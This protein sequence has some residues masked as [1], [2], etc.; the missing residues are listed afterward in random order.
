[1]P[2]W[3]RHGAR[4]LD[5]EPGDHRGIGVLR[6][7]RYIPGIYH[8]DGIYRHIPVPLCPYRVFE[9]PY[10]EISAMSP[11]HDLALIATLDSAPGLPPKPSNAQRALIDTGAQA[12]DT[13]LRRVGL[14]REPS[15]APGEP[16]GFRGYSGA[17]MKNLGVYTT[18]V[19]SAGVSSRSRATTT[20]RS[21]G[22]PPILS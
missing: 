12:S 19:K 16:S 17:V 5:A 4:W 11:V 1:M 20:P 9:H 2:H 13:R 22:S 10:A 3:D 7:Y 8:T 6:K 15:G 18:P 14:R 21:K